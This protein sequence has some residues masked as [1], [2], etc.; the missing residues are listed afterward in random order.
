VRARTF[1]FLTLP[2]LI[3]AETAAHTLVARL[4]PEESRHRVLS[5]ALE[6]F[7]LPFVA[8]VLLLAAAILGRRVLASFR[9]EGPQPLPSWRLAGLPALAFLSQEYVE[10]LMHD[11]RIGW[12]TAL[13]PVILIGVALQVVWG[14]LA[15]W[16][17][18]ALLRA[19]EQLGCTLARRSPHSARRPQRLGVK[20]FRAPE[21]RLPVLASQHAGR[22]PPAVA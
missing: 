8:V 7:A 4:D 17:A 13:E 22:A 5:N 12:L 2:A 19:A 1:W 3:L 6:D 15:I 21:P 20:P 10:Q 14:L 18:R 16:L 11:G 9:A